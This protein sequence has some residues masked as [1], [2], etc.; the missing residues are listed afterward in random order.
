MRVE[1]N[2]RAAMLIAHGLAPGSV[3]L[4]NLPTHDQVFLTALACCRADLTFLSLTP[5]LAPDEIADF[6][7]RT[8]AWL[9]LTPD[10]QPH[11]ALPLCPALPL[12]LPGRPPHAAFTEAMWRSHEGKA[13][14][15]GSLQATSGTTGSRSKIVRQPHRLY[16]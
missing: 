11:S 15:I 14:A 7:R 2:R 13:E 5:K 16:T 6:A 9:I 3:V 1:M 8:Q 4:V 10:G 12:A